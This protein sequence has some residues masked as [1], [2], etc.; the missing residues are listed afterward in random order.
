MIS[1]NTMVRADQFL[2]HFAHAARAKGAGPG[3][4]A[5]AA[6]KVGRA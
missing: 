4:S 2:R 6:A 3:A 1:V 5:Q